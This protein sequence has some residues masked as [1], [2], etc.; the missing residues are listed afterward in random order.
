MAVGERTVDRVATLFL[1]HLNI[2][3]PNEET[4]LIEEGLLDSLVLVELIMAL[5]NEFGITVEFEDFSL[6]NFRSINAIE[7]Y[8]LSLVNS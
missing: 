1:R 3:V 4:D 6:D 2:N 8:I 7:Q 5:E